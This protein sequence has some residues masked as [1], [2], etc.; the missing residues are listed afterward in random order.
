MT[1][2]QDHLVFANI[3]PH[4][5]HI[6][7]DGHRFQDFN[8]EWESSTFSHRLRPFNLDD[9]IGRFRDHA[10]GM[11]N[12]RLPHRQRDISSSPHHDLPNDH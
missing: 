1:S 12:R 9:S 8:F 7:A 3:L 11:D 10:A 4:L 6:L 5:N 2:G